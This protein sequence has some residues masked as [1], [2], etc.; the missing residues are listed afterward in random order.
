MGNT[1]TTWK[2]YWT[3]FDRLIGLLTTDNQVALAKSFK[4][5][6][7]K[8]RIDYG[9]YLMPKEGKLKSLSTKC[10]H[11]CLTFWGHFNYAALSVCRGDK[12]SNL[13]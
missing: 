6:Q 4:E 12:N 5:S 2:E 13:P 9:N 1:F 11:K 10:P 7:L 3:L 8:F